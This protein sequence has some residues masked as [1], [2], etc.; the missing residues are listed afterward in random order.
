MAS[1]VKSAIKPFLDEFEKI[2]SQTAG[3]AVQ[4]VKSAASD[5]VQKPIQEAVGNKVG[6][7]P[8]A[9]TNENLQS[10]QTAAD[11]K[12][13]AAKQADDQQ[14]V[15]QNLAQI[16]ENLKALMTPTKPPPEKPIYYKMWEEK[17]DEEEKK[18]VEEQKKQEEVAAVKAAGHSTGE[19][20]RRIGG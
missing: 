11:A 20:E 3:Q 5:V 6:G 9:G 2:G 14:K 18:Q 16:R 7:P 10:G 4:A 19:T 15:Q 13:L 1:V 8:G 12:A 17:K